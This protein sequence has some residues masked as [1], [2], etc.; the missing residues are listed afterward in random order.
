MYSTIY[1]AG[2]NLI[3]DMETKGSLDRTVAA[4]LRSKNTTSQKIIDE[5]IAAVVKG[6]L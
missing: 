4:R 1:P 5:L 6:D 2:Q 3:V